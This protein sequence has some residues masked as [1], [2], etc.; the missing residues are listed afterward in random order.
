MRFWILAL[1]AACSGCTTLSLE[2]HALTQTNSS[3]D[4]RYLE[5]LNNLA[6]TAA[7]PSA[8]P[9]F[10]SIYTGTV[11]VTDTEQVA[12]TTVWQN[13]AYMGNKEPTGLFSEAV[14]PQFNRTVLENWALDPIS[15][16]EKLEAMR[17]ACQWVVCGPEAVRDEAGLLLSP[18]NAPPNEPL[19]GRHF[20][21]AKK[22]EK[23][24]RG[25]LHVGRL[26]DVP[27]CAS[28]KAHSGDV[29][30]WVLPDG[31]KGLADFSLLLLDVARINSNSPTLFNLP[32]NPFPLTF[33]TSDSPV[34]SHPGPDKAPRS[35]TL[36]ATV[37]VDQNGRLAP[38][39]PYYRLRQD[40]VGSDSRFRSEIS[41][42]GV[43]PAATPTAP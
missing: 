35:I 42:A 16:P 10:A 39:S 21:V 20:G 23:L 30:V 6:Q 32:A 9:T 13:L 11:Q 34:E 22:L 25:W 1:A 2:R 5:T 33:E 12:S 17:L 38:D 29:W 24:P 8:L 31:I 27:A 18:D 7:D 37:S 40:N 41:A 26:K 4:L 15:V 36:T 3:V 43:N 14:T 28:Y 19:P